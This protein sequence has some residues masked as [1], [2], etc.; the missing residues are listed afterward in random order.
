M[1]GK[2]PFPGGTTTDKARAHCELRPL[3]PRRLNPGLIAEFVDVL[4]N[5]MAKDPADRLQSAAEV[6]D[7]L[8]PWAC[9]ATPPTGEFFGRPACS[10]GRLRDH[11]GPP[12]GSC[13]RR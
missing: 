3:D 1:T 5:M 4:A 7:R 11:R 8:A 9:L 10:R 6:I 12:R 2:V 13:R